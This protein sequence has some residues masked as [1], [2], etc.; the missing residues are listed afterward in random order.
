MP[1]TY[2]GEWALT[3]SSH[4]NTGKYPMDLESTWMKVEEGRIKE[5][6]E[7]A[8][9]PALINLSRDKLAVRF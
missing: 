1:S 9:K 4:Q 8:K 2:A 6:D 7:K 3:E 5:L